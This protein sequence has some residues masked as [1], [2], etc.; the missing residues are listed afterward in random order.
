MKKVLV[1]TSVIA[2]ILCAAGM[3][4]FA[5]APAA[6]AK[7]YTNSF[8]SKDDL[9]DWQAY[10]ILDA[11]QSQE[12]D[13]SKHWVHENGAVKRV[14]D[15]VEGQGIKYVAALTLKD[16]TFKNFELSVKYQKT[17]DDWPWAVVAIRQNFPGKYFLDD[18]LGIFVQ[19]EGM[20][21]FWGAAEIGGP[22][23]ES[24]DKSYRKNDAHV[25]KIRAVNDLVTVYI[26]GRQA[27][28]KSFV[29]LIREGYISLMAVNNT[30]IFDD[31]SITRLDDSGD[32]VAIIEPTTTTNAATGTTARSSA[33][34]SRTD[35]TQPGEVSD[36]ETV[37]TSDSA[38]GVS[39]ATTA[40]TTEAVATKAVS[41]EDLENGKDSDGG[42]PWAWVV[43]GAVI[44]LGG[45][46]AAVYFLV[47]RKKAG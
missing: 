30:V 23:E 9:G 5:A 39:D 36:T 42:F 15:I 32:P 38:A 2:A 16:Y 43:I 24:A 10:Y 28:Q 19:D 14:N 17:G 44:V 8:G 3:H 27:A 34:S 35:G 33:T 45:A 47:I 4:A 46:G 22:F 18:G 13:F 7:T 41:L 12:E 21:T 31:F 40:G 11:G 26:D 25:M 20:A 29:S 37:G 6:G 1:I